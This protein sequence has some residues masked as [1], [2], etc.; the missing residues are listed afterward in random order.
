MEQESASPSTSISKLLLLW[1]LRL[2]DG[3]LKKRGIPIVNQIEVNIKNALYYP[4]MKNYGEMIDSIKDFQYI[5]TKGK[6][7][8][9]IGQCGEGGWGLSYNLAGREQFISGEIKMDGKLATLADLENISWYIGEGISSKGFLPKGKSIIN[10]LEEAIKRNQ[11]GTIHSATEIIELFN[12]SQDRLNLKLEELSWEK[13]K[14]SIAI[15][16]AYGKQIFCFPWMSTGWINDLIL[17]CGIHI[18]IDILK[19]TDAIIILPTQM[20]EGVDYFV[21]EIV[22]LRNSRHVPSQRA[23]E[24][25]EHYIQ[26]K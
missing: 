1:R 21:D 15:G 13:W 6:S 19:S 2:N 9:I 16:Y 14:A 24:N 17:N 10:Q 20:A 7:Y 4:K 11:S 12:L 8:G 25:V 5:F 23:K 18:C 26:S 22:F 3:N